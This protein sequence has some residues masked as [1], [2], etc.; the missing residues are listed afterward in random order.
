MARLCRRLGRSLSSLVVGLVTIALLGALGTSLAFAAPASASSA[1]SE[2]SG[3]HQQKPH[4]TC[5][6]KDPHLN[7]GC[8]LLFNDVTDPNGNKGLIVCF[9]TPPKNVV[10]G[11]SKNCSPENARG[12]AYG[13]FLARVCGRATVYALERSKVNGKIHFRTANVVIDVRCRKRSAG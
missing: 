8:E 12:N 11:A 7:G 5:T 2:G 10:I 13:V 6:P 1:T 9:S 3:Y 4:L